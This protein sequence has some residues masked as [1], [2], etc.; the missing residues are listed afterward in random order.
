MPNP[1]R[2]GDLNP[3][4]QGSSFKYVEKAIPLVTFSQTKQSKSIFVFPGL[5]LNCRFRRKSRSHSNDGASE[6]S[7]G[8]R[9]GCRHVPHREEL[10]A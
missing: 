9:V 8:C 1:F 4:K 5:I 6:G 10:L 2:F 7:V 3:K